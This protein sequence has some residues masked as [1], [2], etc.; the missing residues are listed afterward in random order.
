MARPRFH[1]LRVADRRQ[2]TRTCLSFAFAVPEIL[3]QAYR[4]M[5]GQ[6]LTLRAMIA[7]TEVRRSYSIC[8]APHE[9][10]LR[11]AVKL[12][13][14]GAFS[15]WAQDSLFAGS[16]IDVMTPDG[17]FGIPPEPG[18]ARAL[19]AIAA[20]SGITPIM[21]ILKTALSEERGPFFLLYGNRTSAEI[22]FR[23]ELEDLKDRHL[24]RLSVF[25]VLSREQQEFELL[26]G[27]LDAEKVGLLLRQV[28]PVHS[29]AHAFLCGPQPMI[30]GLGPAL[31]E[32]GLPE[33]AIHIERFTPGAAGPPPP[34]P[35][36]ALPA[37][38]LARATIIA[39]GATSEIDVAEGETILEA[40][41]RAGLNL[42]YSCR[43]GM[44]CTCRA[45]LLEGQA[46]MDVNYSLE[47]WELQAGYVLTCQARPL[48]KRLTVDYDHL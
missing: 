22:I 3:A 48:T 30:E 38:V 34:L 16:E 39:E 6:Y 41:T 7:G 36:A 10:E 42:P 20:G 28:V 47:P 21:S 44:C 11:V 12:L 27:R 35:S 4:F 19:L 33:P 31:A 23:G 14:G 1:R 2:E 43:G 45:R 25:H 9:N 18:S 29:L 5:P 13:K 8:S 32:A 24:G 40:G 15:A 26:T 46:A 17:R 37:K